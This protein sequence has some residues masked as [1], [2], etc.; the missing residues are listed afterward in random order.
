MSRDFR[1]RQIDRRT[2]VSMLAASMLAGCG[3]SGIRSTDTGADSATSS[4]QQARSDVP[5]RILIAGSLLADSQLEEGQSAD[6]PSVAESIRVAW[7]MTQDQP[8]KIEVFDGSVFA[9]PVSDEPAASASP[10]AATGKSRATDFATQML[11]ADVAIA[12]QSYLGEIRAQDAAVRFSDEL[13]KDYQTRYGKPFPAVINGLGDYGGNTWGIAVGAKVLALLALDSDVQCDSWAAYHDWVEQLDGKAAEPLAP[14]W[15]GSSFLNR[16]ASSFT[17]R[18]L[19]N[20]TTMKPEIDSE[21]YVAALEQLAATAK[22]YPA[23]AMTPGQIWHAIRRGELAGGI[24][25]EVPDAVNAAE[26][27]QRTADGREEFEVSVFDCPRETETDQLWLG[28]QTPLACLSSGCRQTSASKQ[29]IGW[30]SGGERISTVRQQI[31][32][33]S[34]TRT[35]PGND[36]SPSG[37]PY[38][39]WLAERLQTL[40]VTRGLILPGADR[41]Y[42][43]LDRQVL[44]CLAGEQSAAEALADAATQW[45]AITDELG[46]EQQS[47]AWKRTLG[48]GG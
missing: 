32:L 1:S 19:F 11:L 7:S 39:R 31:G 24:G 16:C 3:D 30:L 17:R 45:D 2:A 9:G 37:S 26:S 43:V 35:T 36:S 21:D 29:F 13:L 46:R 10:D 27:D 41:Y 8:L 22:Q 40:Q 18:W 48:F 28:P 44:R 38:M 20:R 42:A 23:T 6:G 33:F 34:Q 25:Y 4:A 47:V 5:L 15:A 14:G 12:P